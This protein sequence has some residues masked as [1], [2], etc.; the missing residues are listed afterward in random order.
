MVRENSILKGYKKTEVGVI[1]EDWEVR[2]LGEIALDI[3]SG[4]SKVKHEQGSYKVYGSTGVIGFNNF[5]D[6][7]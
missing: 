2:K 7:Q 5:Y 4:K 6:Y 1:P 3:S